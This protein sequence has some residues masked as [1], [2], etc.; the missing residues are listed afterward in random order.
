MRF[1]PSPPLS[2]DAVDFVNQPAT[3]DVRPLLTVMPRVLTKLDVGLASYL[4]PARSGVSI[5]LID[6]HRA[7]A[8]A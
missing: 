7:P 3:V 6:E 4:S 2:P 8:A 5:Q 1:L